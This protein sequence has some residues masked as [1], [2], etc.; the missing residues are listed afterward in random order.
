M[1]LALDCETYLTGPGRAAPRLVCLSMGVPP[2]AT[3]YHA[4]DDWLDP[5]IVGLRD[6]SEVVNHNLS[7]DLAVLVAEA[8]GRMIRGE[9]TRAAFRELTSAV[10]DVYADDRARC[11]YVIAI[12][13]AIARGEPVTPTKRRQ[14]RLPGFSLGALCEAYLGEKPGGKGPDT[15]RTRYH[16]LIDV[17][18]SDWPPEAIAYASDDPLWADRLYQAI[19]ASVGG[20]RL[21]GEARHIRASWCQQLAGCWGVRTDGEIGRVL[22][23]HLDRE[24]S[25]G[26]AL[27]RAVVGRSGWLRE[28]GSRDMAQLSERVE[29]VLTAGGVWDPTPGGPHVTDK[30]RTRTDRLTLEACAAFGAEDLGA[31]ARIGSSLTDRNTFVS[32]LRRGEVLPIHARWFPL[33][34]SGRL[35]CREPNLTNQP[36]REAE[37][38]GRRIGVRHGFVPRDGFLFA[39]ADYATAELRAFAQTAIEWFGASAMADALRAEAEAALRGEAALDLHSKLAARILDIDDAEALRRKASD[40]DFKATRQLAK[41]INFG[42]LGMMGAPTFLKTCEADG[43]DLTLGGRLGTDP[44]DVA[45][46][47]LKL[48]GDTWPEVPAY[49]E[50]ILFQLR[51]TGGAGFRAVSTG[52]GLIRG[53]VGAADGANHYF[54]NRVAQWV[55][56]AWFLLSREGYTTEDQPFS[57][58]RP[59][60][61]P[62]DEVI[63]EVPEHRAAKAAERLADVMHNVA[64]ENCP[65]VPIVVEPALMRRWF[66]GA[67][68]VRDASGALV[69][70]EP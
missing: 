55:K 28:D 46:R 2:V 34:E 44:E 17:P 32:T 41:R 65:D 56:D 21:R 5:L 10:W 47:L 58:C 13:M 70:W 40:P 50:R 15:W 31:Y 53:S 33:V 54:Q 52:D 57:G 59:V 37:V 27:I 11:T 24:I 61:V 67:E 19:R 64:S 36:A 7:Y 66:K 38:D 6:A 68:T 69:V 35:S 1:R 9:I 43:F 25:E 16:A 63:A 12:L 39:A 51:R 29:A 60:I 8:R 20:E 4:S 18:L 49:F 62:H 22:A 26:Y 48:W 23:E 14:Q 30:G 3:L 45:R 42:C